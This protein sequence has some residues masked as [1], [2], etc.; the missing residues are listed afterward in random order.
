MLWS[1]ASHPLIFFFP[2]PCQLDEGVAGGGRDPTA[3]CP[4]KTL[5]KK[6]ASLQTHGASRVVSSDF[7][8]APESAPNRLGFTGMESGYR[9]QRKQASRMI[10]KVVGC[11]QVLPTNKQIRMDT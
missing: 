4:P 2:L 9:C 7:G 6:S 5:Q 1:R 3:L 8:R 10:V 11:A